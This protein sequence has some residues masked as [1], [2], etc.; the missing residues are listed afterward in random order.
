MIFPGLIGE[1]LTSTK[2]ERWL[3]GAG[4][5]VKFPHRDKLRP[6]PEGTPDAKLPTTI[7][8]PPLPVDCTGDGSV[9]AP[10][11]WNNTLGDCM[12]AMSCHG[13]NIWTY[14]QGKAG[15]T[16]S[17]F[18]QQKIRKQYLQKS[19]GDNGLSESDLVASNGIWKVGLAGNKEACIVDHLNVNVKNVALA[20]YIIANF[21]HLPMMWSVPDAFINDFKAKAVFANAMTPDPNNGHGTPLTDVVNVPGHGSTWFYRLYTWGAYAYVSQAFVD[22]V[23]PQCF[24]VLSA[25]QFNASGFDSHGN[26]VS[27]IGPKWVAIGG[28][29]S[30][31][32]ALIA[33]FPPL[34]P[35]HDLNHVVAQ[36]AEFSKTLNIQALIKAF[37]ALATAVASG[38][39]AEIA[40]D[41]LAV[42][43]A[44]G[45]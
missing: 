41:V 38:N 32:A 25:R 2:K 15:Y 14:G 30:A 21:Y 37:E 4:H 16:E 42:I 3:P 5:F 13:D 22:S 35:S 29:A 23:D 17:V 39:V 24:A 18:N 31:A 43:K 34:P 1:R 10:M 8:A 20:Q 36:F 40:V 6:F 44:L 27:V 9:K 12:E 19:G 7:V 11:D 28:S 26:H 45:L 33:K